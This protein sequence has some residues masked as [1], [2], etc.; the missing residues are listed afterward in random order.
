MSI[1]SL[2]QQI[3]TLSEQLLSEL[4]ADIVDVD[5]LSGVMEQ[6]SQAIT[7]LFKEHPRES[8]TEFSN[9]LNHIAR[10]DNLLVDK[11]PQRQQQRAQA[12]RKV[13]G[14]KQAIAAYTKG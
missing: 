10:L 3:I 14:N 13:K 1:Q 12:I 8:L 6:R 5:S 7:K 9:E 2:T 4:D 11:A